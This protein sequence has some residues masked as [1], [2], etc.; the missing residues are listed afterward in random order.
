MPLA[1]VRFSTT[2]DWPRISD[3]FC[4]DPRGDVGAA[5]GAETDQHLDRPVGIGRVLRAGKVMAGTE[6]ERETKCDAQ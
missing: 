3:I 4:H 5:A 6:R 2:I 1:P